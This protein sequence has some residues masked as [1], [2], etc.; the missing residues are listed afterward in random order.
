MVFWIK[1]GFPKRGPLI[2][3]H[4]IEWQLGFRE[5]LA[6]GANCRR[7]RKCVVRTS[8]SA[9]LELNAKVSR[10]ERIWIFFQHKRR[11]R[12]RRRRRQQHSHG[13]PFGN[14]TLVSGPF[15][16][17]RCENRL[18]HVECQWNKWSGELVSFRVT[19]GVN[20]SI[21]LKCTQ[22][23]AALYMSRFSSC[24]SI[25]RVSPRNWCYAIEMNM[26]KLVKLK[27][28]CQAYPSF[29][30]GDD[31]KPPK[32]REMFFSVYPKIGTWYVASM[33][34]RYAI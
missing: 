21:M 23:N 7:P 12:C 32:V 15:R 31:K 17:T 6:A 5:I 16:S 4:R 28:C 10:T 19:F 30:E 3:I 29:E 22:K 20:Y 8:E 25:N 33:G 26:D 18:A 11:Q 9:Q 34:A 27:I 14:G 13:G 24:I 1:C 2:F